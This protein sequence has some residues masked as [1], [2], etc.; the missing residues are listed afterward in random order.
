MA[1]LLYAV[2]RRTKAG[3]GSAGPEDHRCADLHACAN[4][5]IN[6]RAC[7]EPDLMAS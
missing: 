5:T 2:A 6:R 4:T 7:A 1:K 3:N